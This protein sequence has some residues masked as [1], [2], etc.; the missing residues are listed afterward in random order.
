MSCSDILPIGRQIWIPG[1]T[2]HGKDNAA[3]YRFDARHGAGPIFHPFRSA[4]CRR[5]PPCAGTAA[6]LTSRD[7][8]VRDSA[9]R[10]ASSAPIVE[11]LA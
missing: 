5:A 2:M 8:P 3:W 7:G 11:D 4:P 1:T 10:R 9:H 6:R